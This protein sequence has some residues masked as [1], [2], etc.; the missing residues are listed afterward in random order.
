MS[1]NYVGLTLGKI[2]I[3]EKNIYNSVNRQRNSNVRT[4]LE[5]WTIRVGSNRQYRV[6]V[7]VGTGLN[8]DN[9]FD[10]TIEADD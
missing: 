1:S 10:G 8:I 7:S 9:L 6:S 2:V 5:E 4:L 3:L